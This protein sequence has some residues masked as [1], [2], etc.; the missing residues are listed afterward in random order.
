VFVMLSKTSPK[1]FLFFVD[2]ALNAKVFTFSILSYK[3]MLISLSNYPGYLA[4]SPDQ[5]FEI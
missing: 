4:L 5:T 2:I 1:Q 3:A